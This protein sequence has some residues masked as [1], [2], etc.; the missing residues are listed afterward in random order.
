MYKNCTLFKSK[1]VPRCPLPVWVCVLMQSPS[2]ENQTALSQTTST[3]FSRPQPGIHRPAGK[4]RLSS[5]YLVCPG[6]SPWL[7][8]PGTPPKRGIQEASKQIQEPPK[9][10]RGSLLHN[11]V[12]LLERL[13]S[14]IPE[15]W[16]TQSGLPSWILEPT[17]RSLVYNFSAQANIKFL[18]QWTSSVEVSNQPG[19]HGAWLTA[20]WV[21]HSYPD[22]LFDVYTL[23]AVRA[24]F[25]TKSKEVQSFK[26]YTRTPNIQ[27]QVCG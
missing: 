16:N 1:L 5:V 14:V 21:Q 2:Q 27:A 23:I 4:H 8:M 17:S 25:W 6:A 7:G 19:P 13:R 22:L 15:S 20:L 18:H 3:S 10:G 11:K 12:T 24:K 26:P 9:T